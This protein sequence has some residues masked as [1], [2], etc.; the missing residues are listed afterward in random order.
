[1][2]LNKLMKGIAHEL[3]QGDG[4]EEIKKITN[5]SRQ[6]GAGEL[7]VAL[8]GALTDGHDYIDQ[9]IEKGAK[10]ILCETI[11]E[12]R[13]PGVAYLRVEHTDAVIGELAANFYDHPSEKLKLVG[14][15]GT[16]GK[17]T[18][19][20]LLYRL[21][22]GLGHK[23]G[24][25]STVCVIVDKEEIPS[26]L[27]TPD[28]LSLQK[29]FA[30]M[31]DAGCE[32]AFME[33]SSHSVVQHRIGGAYFRGGI[34]TNLTRD[35]LDFHKTFENYL[36][37]KQ[38]FF[39]DL[40]KEAFALTNLDE[41][42]GAVMV[43]NT[44]ADVYGYALKRDADFKGRILEQHLDGT[45][46]LFDGTE[47]TTR[48]VGTFNAYNLLAVY[49]AALLLGAPKDEVLRV[50][51][52]LRPVDGRF[53]T[54]TS[55]KGYVTIVDYAHTPDALKN[56]LET[57]SDLQKHHGGRIITVVGAGGNRD[58]GKR[59]I[60]A[61]TAAGLS[62]ILILTSD[63]P[64]DEDPEAILDMMWEGLNPEDVNHSL[65]ITSR[66]EAIRTACTMALP[67]DIVLIAG[68]GHETYQ[69]VKGVRH[70]FSDVE[71]VEMVFDAQKQ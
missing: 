10:A 63:N 34:F 42:N 20:T 25:I 3:I 55:P 28:A 65:R 53:Q 61:S 35:H 38:S 71:E 47:A 12:I 52:S 70:H 39:D 8:R 43:Q 64:R 36:H 19:A 2:L 50:L 69:E 7:F 48:L 18:I 66:R 40:P 22:N 11:P 31:V 6:V 49:G 46:M 44:K 30:Q 59:P 41:T 68:K 27:T 1:M 14:V 57:L 32:Y 67:K 45:D 13:K 21:F 51:S 9:S 54:L 4:N 26:K 5:D 37:A 29:Y 15:T 23:S 58:H 56:V 16:N 62:D 60:M 24:L 17:T 33:V